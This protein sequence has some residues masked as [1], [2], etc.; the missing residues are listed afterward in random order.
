MLKTKIISSLSRVFTD[1]SIDSFNTLERISALKGE[2]VTFQLVHQRFMDPTDNMYAYRELFTPRF[3][4][5]LAKYIT[6]REVKNVGVELPIIVGN[7]D[8]HYERTEPGLYPD[9]LRPLHYGGQTIAKT[10]FP[11]SL[12]IE[13]DIPAHANETGEC[14]LKV[15][16]V[17]E[18]G[19]VKSENTIVI[20]VINATL[21][22]QQLILTQWFHSDSLANYYDVEVWSEKH[23]EIVEN[24]ARVA[25]RNGINLLLTPTFTPSLDTKIGGERL[26]NQLVGVTVENGKIKSVK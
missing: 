8:E 4:G 12:W 10:A 14:E 16:M 15:E 1:S 17:N 24:F 21:P 26:T 6:V 5:D 18:G 23:W 2:R 7:S 9:V 19:V 3:T 22:E 13:V 25:H 20:D 11:T